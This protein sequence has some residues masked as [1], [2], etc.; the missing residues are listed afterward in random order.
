MD[1][2]YKSE[3]NESR[4][5][6]YIDHF[7]ECDDSEKE[8]SMF[9]LN[10]STK[11]EKQFWDLLIQLTDEVTEFED[12]IS[13]QIIKNCLKTYQEIDDFSVKI[14]IVK[15]IFH[16]IQ[17]SS[18]PLPIFQDTQLL[19]LIIFAFSNKSYF[20]NPTVFVMLIEIFL[21][22]LNIIQEHENI[23]LPWA[24]ELITNINQIISSTGKENPF[25]SSLLMISSILF[26][27]CEVDLEFALK[28]CDFYLQLL[29]KIDI[30]T[31]RHGLKIIEIILER[32]SNIYEILIKSP[33]FPFLL[34]ISQQNI[35][36]N[37]RYICNILTP[38]IGKYIDA[39]DL[40]KIELNDQKNIIQ[41][42]LPNFQMIDA[43]SALSI[44]NLLVALCENSF[45][46]CRILT[47]CG[48]FHC[49]NFFQLGYETQKNVLKITNL[50][51]K[52]HSIPTDKITLRFIFTLVIKFFDSS[53]ELEIIMALEITPTI[54]DNNNQIE[55]ELF[56]RLEELSLNENERISYHA[57]SILNLIPS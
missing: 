23:T 43:E 51:Y 7:N 2:T 6:K 22:Y 57:K 37:V 47:E 8:M 9:F 31:L 49:L 3:Q 30:L 14:Q 26:E 17:I 54:I 10:F 1:F 34:S 19:S 5:N 28:N 11:H 15:V 18:N 56:N 41:C 36:Y 39:N 50:I 20:Q 32:Y 29:P 46:A 24:I 4:N 45:E 42:L 48:F 35:V 12:H 52:N 16:I 44:S 40:I 13:L 53:D 25:F 27:K 33:I 55:E 38:A 21:S